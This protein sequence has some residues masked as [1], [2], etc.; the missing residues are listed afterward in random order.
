MNKILLLRTE[1]GRKKL[2]FKGIIENEPLDLEIIY[3]ILKDE[4]EVSIFDKQV[5]EISVKK[6]L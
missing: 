6:Y 4:Y 5:E 2:D 1:E 3:T